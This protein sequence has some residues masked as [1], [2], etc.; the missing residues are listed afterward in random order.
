M[1][2]PNKIRLSLASFRQ[3]V[4]YYW[5]HKLVFGI[6]N[7]K[8]DISYTVFRESF[9]ADQYN[10]RSFLDRIGSANRILFLDIGRNHGFVFYYAMFHI[11]K[12]RFPVAVIDYYGIDPAPLKFVYFN[13]HDYLVK[14]NI[15]VNY[16]I[17][18][19]AIVFDGATHALLKYGERNYG[20]FNVS[21]S[22]YSTTLADSQTLFEYVTLSVEAMPF[23]ELVKLIEDDADADATIVKIDC[24]NRS[25]YIFC[26]IH[27]ILSA[28]RRPYLVS[29]ERDGSADEDISNYV[30]RGMN[31]LTASR[32]DL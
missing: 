2:T 8:F 21:G 32:I 29:C 23:S 1:L 14:N 24:K 28:R 30:R 16:H 25:D 27:R 31:V 12:I 15:K 22:N 19:R 26:A 9:L 6:T 5:Y 3:R 10:I 18:N 20:N 4:M 13:F 11:M 7:T 17:I